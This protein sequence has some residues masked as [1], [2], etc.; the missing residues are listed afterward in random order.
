MGTT[1]DTQDWG[2]LPTVCRVNIN[3]GRTG[4][5][6]ALSSALWVKGVHLTLGGAMPKTLRKESKKYGK[7]YT[8]SRR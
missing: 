2:D 1:Q 4:S 8:R 6:H 5:A 3:S 7:F